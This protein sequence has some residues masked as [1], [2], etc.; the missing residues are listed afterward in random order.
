MDSYTIGVDFG[1][2]SARAVLVNTQTGEVASSC[3][4]E[5]GSGV[6]DRQLPGSGRSLPD[7]WALQNPVDWINS[8]QKVVYGVMRESRIAPERIAGLGFDFTSCTILPTDANGT[9]LCQRQGLVDVPHAWPKLWKHHAAQSQADLINTLAAERDQRWL[10]RYGGKLSCEWLLPK[11]LELADEAPE[12]YA[13]ADQII[14]AADWVVW[15]MTGKL[16]RNACAAGYKACWHHAEG[17]PPTSFLRLLHPQLQD[18]YSL[19]WKGEV[20]VPGQ[21]VGTLS[22][23]WSGRLGLPPSTAVAAPMIDAHAAALGAGLKKAGTLFM[24]MGTST[25]HML[26]SD[27]EVLIPGMCGVAKDGI[28]PGLFGYEAGQPAVGDIFGWLVKQGLPPSFHEEAHQRKCSLHQV[29]S[30]KAARLEAGENGLLALDW[31]NGNRSILNNADLSGMILGYSLSTQPE[32]IY[33]A[34]VEAT[35]FG[36]R[37]I[38]ENFAT[39]GVPVDRILAGGGLT[40]NPLVLQIY[41]DVLGQ[42][43]EVA[44]A[45]HVAAL[46]AAIL[47][48]VA[49]GSDGGGHATIEQAIER[50]APPPSLRVTFSQK[51]RG[52]YDSLYVIYRQLHDYFGRE[53]ST[54][55]TLQSLR[56]TTV[57]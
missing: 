43:V 41:A 32:E 21:Q 2:E 46:G 50:M 10:K 48:A 57:A 11:I 26:L 45:V 3:V 17:A 24:I 55:Q 16:V 40:R 56:R 6:I 42:D 23:D 35:A 36:A 53:T 38:A 20:A 47:A 31:W 34:L 51:N 19:K 49:A 54:M 28:L 14:E 30:E 29:V 1:T 4:D 15:Q 25:C 9:P 44:G 27:Q 5:Y 37:I 52:I 7:A 12:V 8:L 22:K 33:R 13:A 39:R 18:F